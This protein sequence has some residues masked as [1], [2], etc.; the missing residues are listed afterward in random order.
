[1]SASLA[2]GSLINKVSFRVSFRTSYVS[3][4]CSAFVFL[5]FFRGGEMNELLLDRLLP[6]RDRVRRMPRSLPS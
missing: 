2:R 3:A 6:L 1:M 4:L 5:R